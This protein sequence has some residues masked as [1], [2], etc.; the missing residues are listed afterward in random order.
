MNDSIEAVLGHAAYVALIAL[1]VWYLL[2]RSRASGVLAPVIVGLAL[3]TGLMVV[4]H[5]VSLARDEGGI[6]FLDDRTYLQVGMRIAGAWDDWEFINPAAYDYAGTYQ[7]GYQTLV[8]GAFVLIDDIVAGKIFNV[9][10]SAATV[11]LIALISGRVWGAQARRRAAWIAALAPGLVWWSAPLMKEAFAAFLTTGA[12]LALLS[13]SR[14]AAMGLVAALAGLALSRV[15]GAVAVVAAAVPVFGVLIVRHRS[16]LPIARIALVACGL[17]ALGGA[18]LLAVSGGDLGGLL[19]SYQQL[20]DSMIGQY[21]DSGVEALPVE[22]AKAF[23]SPYPWT[24]DEATHNWDMGLY[25]GMWFWYTLYPL[26]ALGIWRH[27]RA[28]VLLLAGV[29]VV[30][31][32]VNAYSAGFIFRQRSS[33][34]PLVVV[35][36]VGGLT[37]WRALAISAAGA[38]TVVAFFAALQSRG[39]L[40][41]IAAVLGGAG[42]A[43]LLSRRVSNDQFEVAPGSPLFTALTGRRDLSVDPGG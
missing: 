19:A 43:Y 3:R 24:F 25:P 17:V 10:A 36:A 33:I 2:R 20:V 27:R 12:V 38:W 26:A 30:F 39:D 37:S 40:I 15:A 5:L 1:A 4:I 9:L 7:F 41:T 23:V 21:R 35:L 29:I 32:A 31:L 13:L 14:R 6:M 8:A 16:R 42:A 22:M 18:G 11:L 34:D 28:E